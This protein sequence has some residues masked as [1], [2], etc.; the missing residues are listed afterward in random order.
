MII[1]I[2]IISKASHIKFTYQQSLNDDTIKETIDSNN[3]EINK[4]T[5]TNRFFLIILLPIIIIIVIHQ[6]KRYSTIKEIINEI[7]NGKY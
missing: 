7:I 5:S 3:N 6:I 4:K 2:I 1:I